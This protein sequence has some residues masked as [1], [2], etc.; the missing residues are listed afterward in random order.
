MATS[1]APAPAPSPEPARA[2]SPRET[3]RSWSTTIFL[4]VATVLLCAVLFPI[5]KPLLLA[6]VAAAF[7]SRL[8]DRL[9]RKLS[10]RRYVSA[11]IFTIGVTVL[12]LAPLAGLVAEAV[13]QAVE[14]AAWIRSSLERGGLQS[15]LRPLPD[16][17][18]NFVR[19]MLPKAVSTLPAGSAAAGRWAAEQMQSAL[20]ALS[21]FAF[22][23][24]MMMIAFFFLLTDGRKLIAWL[25]SVFPL[26]PSRTKELI[27][28]CRTVAR[29]VI[30]SNLLTGLAQTVVATIGYFIAQAPKPLFFALAT[31]LASFIPS[32]G[33]AVVSLPVAALLYLSGHPGWA[34]FLA[35]WSLFVVALID[36]LLRPW[37]IKG[38]VQI[39]GALIFFALIG[40]MLLFGFV[41]LVVGPLALAFF[42]SLVRFHTRDTRR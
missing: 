36:N 23:L 24:A 2:P 11:S 29:S 12:I 22:D 16:T 6:L 34:V 41:G 17:I 3:E 4:A 10:D 19:P 33:T 7:V 18:E 20:G 37:L 13:N 5:W 15:L 28:E 30:G 32:V 35:A 40:G 14:A 31:L 21:N 38:D 8:H 1:P 42:T 26:G 25:V 27:D 39:H 9:A